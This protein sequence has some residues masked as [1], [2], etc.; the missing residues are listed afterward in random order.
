MDQPL[1]Q[2]T[3]NKLFHEARTHSVW[4]D[5]PVTDATL[6]EAYNLM[7]MGPTSMNC[8][9]AR[10]LFL[11]TKEAKE[12]LRPFLMGA[13]V[14]KTMAAPA[15][16]IIGYDLK[17]YD[18]LPQLFPHYPG[19][20]DMFANSPELAQI[21]AFRNGTLQGGYFILAARAAEDMSRP[22]YCPGGRIPAHSWP[23]KGR[24]QSSCFGRFRAP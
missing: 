1:N 6:R 2:A 23:T 14:D 10:I 4:L 11:R 20:R 19:A 7:R 16:A 9:P 12:R 21:A 17:F 15:T 3:L 13:N 8:C 22:E 18:R 24:L 5:R